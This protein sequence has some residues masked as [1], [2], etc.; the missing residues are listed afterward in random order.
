[1]IDGVLGG[2]GSFDGIAYFNWK[3]TS[4]N[5]IIAQNTLYKEL[6]LGFILGYIFA[7]LMWLIGVATDDIT[8]MGQL[9]GVKLV[10][11]EF[12]GYE[13]LAVLKDISN[14]IH[15]T[16]HYHILEY[17]HFRSQFHQF[18][19]QTNH[20]WYHKEHHWLL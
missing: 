17:S 5:Q 1:M 20:L 6:S 16:Y 7:P 4:L 2:I 14:G 15:L 18:P 19:E 8:L 3:F 13:Q 11:S 9:L 10:A 12:I